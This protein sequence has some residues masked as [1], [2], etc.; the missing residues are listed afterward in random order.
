MTLRCYIAY[1]FVWLFL[2]LLL[3]TLMF[4]Y[5]WDQAGDRLERVA[6]AVRQ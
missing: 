6:K 2:I 4:A 5:G 1:P 3:L